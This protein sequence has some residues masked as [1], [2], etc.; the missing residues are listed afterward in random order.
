MTRVRHL[1]LRDI[2]RALGGQIVGGQVSAPGP[3]HSLRYRSLSVRISASS[4]DGFLAYS[5]SGD[6]WRVCRDHV[7]A[8]LGLTG[9]PYKRHTPQRLAAA[10]IRDTETDKRRTSAALDV[11]RR[12]VDPV[13][14]LAERYFAGRGLELGA[15]IAGEAVRWHPRLGAAVALFRNIKTGEPKAVTRIFLDREGRKLARKF[16]G[17]VGGAAVMLDP[18]DAV[19]GGLHIGEGVETCM[20][21]RQLG[22]RPTWALRSCAAI[23]G[24]PIL[25]GVQCLAILAENDAASAKAVRACGSRWHAAERE[26]LINR[27][28]AGGDLN[29]S[30]R[31][32]AA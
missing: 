10:A 28:T 17:P 11:W 27:P 19:S 13:G 32:T 20:A 23:A 12:A 15:D 30:I 2:A 3:G 26:V 7:R 25:A 6:N 14:T 22:L 18:F 16:L 4:P 5:H 9:E 21:A 29:D 8:R 24:F 1:D 31:R